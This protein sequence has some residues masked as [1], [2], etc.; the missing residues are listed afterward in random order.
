M[1]LGPGQK[2]PYRE[3]LHYHLAIPSLNPKTAFCFLNHFLLPLDLSST[4]LVFINLLLMSLLRQ[5]L[6][7]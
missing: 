2:Q 1:L 7:M 4:C 3:A 5:D 6:R